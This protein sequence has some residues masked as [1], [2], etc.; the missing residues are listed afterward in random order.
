[1][2][3]KISSVRKLTKENSSNDIDSII[4]LLL[5]IKE[6]KLLAEAQMMEEVEKRE[7]VRLEAVALFESQ[8]L[9]VPDGLKDPITLQTLI[10]AQPKKRKRG[11][12]I[13]NNTIQ[14]LR[15]KDL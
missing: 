13:G 2:L 12:K 4:E 5:K 15:N 1:M 14:A 8:N 7:Q 9:P 11:S 10:K 6:E 3:T